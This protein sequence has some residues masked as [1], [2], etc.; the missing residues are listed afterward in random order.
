MAKIRGWYMS[1]LGENF[2]ILTPKPQVIFQVQKWINGQNKNWIKGTVEDGAQSRR[3][4]KISWLKQ[5]NT[6]HELLRSAVNKANKNA[7]WYYDITGQDLFQ[8]T[9]YNIGDNYN[10]HL[11]DFK[12][13][14]SMGI[15]K[16][17]FIMSLNDDYEGG[18]LYI[19]E[20]PP[21]SPYRIRKIDLKTGDILLFPSDTWHKVESVTKGQRRSLVCWYYGK[22]S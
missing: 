2:Y 1:N 15:R 10:W 18:K 11:D 13:P 21:D 6:I 7:G 22:P 8:Y 17:S 20:G 3:N 19:E 5:D 14:I 12:E 9:E 4:S 16:I